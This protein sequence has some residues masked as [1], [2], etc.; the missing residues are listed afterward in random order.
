MEAFGFWHKENIELYELILAL[1]L[2]VKVKVMVWSEM[3]SGDIVGDKG[4]MNTHDMETYRYFKE[5]SNYAQGNKNKV[6]CALAPRQYEIKEL[7]DSFHQNF[8]SSMY[9]HHQK[10]MVCDAP[11]PSAQDGRRK[12]IAYVGGL[13]LT[14]GRYDT[15]ADGI[16]RRN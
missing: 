11:D 12:L 4:M 10:S 6:I 1:V 2:M 7:T 13:D 15:P 14:G 3:S 8:A 16:S 9:T 5:S